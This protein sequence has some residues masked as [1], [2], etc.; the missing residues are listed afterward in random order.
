MSLQAL[1]I[2]TRALNATLAHNAEAADR[3]TRAG[4]ELAALRE[5]CAALCGRRQPAQP[6]PALLPLPPPPPPA[7]GR[8]RRGG[9]RERED[10]A[11]AQQQLA[12]A[13]AAL[14]ELRFKRRQYGLMHAR[15]AGNLEAMAAYL[16]AVDA[17]LRCAE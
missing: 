15:L 12:D 4:G 16:A 17:S 3:I 1:H 9:R 11:L 2:K 10:A 8:E 6:P 13:G 7:A 5:E 14:L